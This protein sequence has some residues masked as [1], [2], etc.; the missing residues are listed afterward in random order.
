MKKNYETP[1]VEMIEFNYSD[2]VV[3]SSTKCLAVYTSKAT[4]SDPICEWELQ[5]KYN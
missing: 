5:A 2:Q 4:I 1:C 3:A